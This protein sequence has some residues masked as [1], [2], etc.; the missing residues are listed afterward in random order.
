MN[1]LVTYYNSFSTKTLRLT[2]KHYIKELEDIGFGVYKS[3]EPRVFGLMKKVTAI[4]EILKERSS[5]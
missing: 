1:N 4:R 5:K 3:S 2:L